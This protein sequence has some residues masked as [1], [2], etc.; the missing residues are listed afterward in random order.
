[1]PWAHAALH[2]HFEVTQ[3][4]MHTYPHLDT[5]QYPMKGPS[6]RAMDCAM[7]YC[8]R[9]LVRSSKVV[10]C[11]TRNSSGFDQI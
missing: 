7:R 8:A 9:T 4:T 6:M 2:K 11:R 1:M 5:L 3:N 10:I